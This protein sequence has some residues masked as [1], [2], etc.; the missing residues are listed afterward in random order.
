MEPSTWRLGGDAENEF[1]YMGVGRQLACRVRTDKTIKGEASA[2]FL[3][4]FPLYKS[5][6]DRLRGVT[7]P[8][9]ERE[10]SCTLLL[11]AGRLNLA[12][13]RWMLLRSAYYR[14]NSGR[15]NGA[16]QSVFIE[17]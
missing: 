17:N 12:W 11:L 1:H 15:W 5:C 2:I 10:I 6:C 8:A 13:K 7:S 16:G 14:K 3:L 9:F 4:V